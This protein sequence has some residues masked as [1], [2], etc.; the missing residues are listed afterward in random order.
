M[1]LAG[2]GCG[3]GWPGRRRLN[4]R[5][6]LVMA[7]LAAMLALG[8]GSARAQNAPE[9]GAAAE[10]TTTTLPDPT[11]GQW[12]SFLDP[13]RDFEDNVVTG[14]QKKIEDATKIH[15]GLGFTEAYTWDFNN[16]R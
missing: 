4:M 3:P 2:C 9:G 11:R 15:F 16:P 7:F 8:I 12:D 14:T 10:T 6:T 13:L 5:L 1:R